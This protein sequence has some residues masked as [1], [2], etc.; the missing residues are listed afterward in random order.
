MNKQQ[1]SGAQTFIGFNY[2]KWQKSTFNSNKHE[3]K[4]VLIEAMEAY[5]ARGLR[6]TDF[7]VSFV[8][9]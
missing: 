6:N 2:Q 1:E 7:Y 4:G 3:L 9:W 8:I 5:K